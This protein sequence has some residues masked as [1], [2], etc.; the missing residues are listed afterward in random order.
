MLITFFFFFFSYSR[1]CF[2]SSV[3]FFLSIPAVGSAWMGPPVLTKDQAEQAFPSLCLSSTSWRLKPEFCAQKTHSRCGWLCA[4]YVSGTAPHISPAG[5]PFPD[6]FPS[7]RVRFWPARLC[8]DPA[9]LP[10]TGC[11]PSSLIYS[12]AMPAECCQL[13]SAGQH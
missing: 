12:S 1:E 5:K 7:S 13:H 11:S 10:C 3:C 6:A 4:F 9:A 2:V 8:W